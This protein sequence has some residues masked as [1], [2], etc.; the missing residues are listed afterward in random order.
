MIRRTTPDIR[1]AMRVL[2]TIAELPNHP[3]H[4]GMSWDQTYFRTVYVGD[5]V[6]ANNGAPM[7]ATALCFAGWVVELDPD[8]D[9]A[10]DTMTLRNRHFAEDTGRPAVQQDLILTTAVDLATGHLL[11]ADEYAER[12]LGLTHNQAMTLF[13]GSNTLDDL[14]EIIG[15][16]SKGAL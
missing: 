13:Q 2:T 16:I 4:P 9:W 1:F 6:C 12:R 11:C 3:R 14:A 7:C 10:Y 5:V 8:V 15:S